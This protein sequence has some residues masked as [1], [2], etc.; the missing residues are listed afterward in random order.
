MCW[1]PKGQGLL[2]ERE[3]RRVQLCHCPDKF[4][5]SHPLRASKQERSLIFTEHLLRVQSTVCSI[6]TS[7]Y[8][9]G[10]HPMCWPTIIFFFFLR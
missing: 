3:K 8:N 5:L 9:A 2:G 10:E 1:R 6:F 4:I 7:L